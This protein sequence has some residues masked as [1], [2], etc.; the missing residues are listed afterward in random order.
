[1]ATDYKVL[2]FGGTDE[3]RKIAEYLA[4]KS[5]TALVCVA[6]EYGAKMLPKN[7]EVLQG[8]LDKPEMVKL[9]K[10]HNFTL[11]IDATHPYAGE[12]SENIDKASREANLRL[13]RVV[14]RQSEIEYGRT[15]RSASEIVE[16]LSYKEGNI[17]VTIG[18]KELSEFS[19]IS[20]RVFARILPDAGAV[21]KCNDAGFSGR[22]L[23][24]MQGPFSVDLNAAIMRE[25][26]AKFLV[27][28]ESGLAGGFAE[29]TEAAKEVGAEVLILERPRE[30]TGIN[31]DEVFKIIEKIV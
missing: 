1:M 27:T 3:G 23:I 5:M 10:S 7:V 21:K 14:R 20:D 13:Y 4:E 12:V 30:E 26:E 22:H 24:C 2:L 29:K 16:Y 25:T 18:S 8:R 15:F 28:K 6:T 11:C 17:F 19:T 31:L 9:M